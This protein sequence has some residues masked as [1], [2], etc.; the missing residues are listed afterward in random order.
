MKT[1]R[2]RAMAAPERA[3]SRAGT[4]P[5]VQPRSGGEAAAVVFIAGLLG[6]LVLLWWLI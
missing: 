4:A 1:M 3:P 6:L 5:V 2:V